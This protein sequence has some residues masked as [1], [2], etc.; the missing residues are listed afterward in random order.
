MARKPVEQMTKK[1]QT[2]KAMDL[3]RKQAF[4]EF[5]RGDLSAFYNTGHNSFNFDDM[6]ASLHV[7]R[8]RIRVWYR[9][10]LN[11]K[12]L[13]PS[14]KQLETM[15]EIEKI[16]YEKPSRR[17]VEPV[18]IVESDEELINRLQSNITALIDRYGTVKSQ[19]ETYRKFAESANRALEQA[20]RRD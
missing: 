2:R 10:F 14:D 6:A 17:K 15:P 13:P 18:E 9:R 7:Q 19:K 3:Q 20:L 12:M 5:S 1:W 16:H 8:E 11:G 4:R